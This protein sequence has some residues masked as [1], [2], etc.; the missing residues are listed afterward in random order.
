MTHSLPP[1]LAK[2]SAL[3]PELARRFGVSGVAV[4]GPYARG[5]ARPESDLDLLLDFAAE[6]RPTYFTLARL[7]AFLQET[8]V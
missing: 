1:L 2:L 7:D 4:F 3:T 6:A 5:A 8:W